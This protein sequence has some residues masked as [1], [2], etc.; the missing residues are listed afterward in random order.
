MFLQIAKVA[1]LVM[2]AAALCYGAVFL[3]AVSAQ[4]A[5]L[6]GNDTEGTPWK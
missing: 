4:Y 2:G 6:A 5:H 1:A 3:A